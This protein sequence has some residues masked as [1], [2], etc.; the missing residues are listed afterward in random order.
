MLQILFVVCLIFLVIGG[1]GNTRSVI[2]RCKQCTNLVTASHTPLSSTEA[3]SFVV[4][5]RNGRVAVFAGDDL[6]Q[7]FM[8]YVDPNPLDVRHVGYSTGWGSTGEFVFD[9]CTPNC[10]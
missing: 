4:S 9:M 5:Y 8:E 7:P 1:W 10:Y 2:R 3:R 6:D